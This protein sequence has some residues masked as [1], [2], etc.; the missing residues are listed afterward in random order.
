MA[1]EMVSGL[2]FLFLF[3]PNLIYQRITK[4]LMFTAMEWSC[5]KWL[6]VKFLF[7]VCTHL[8]QVFCTS[9]CLIA[10]VTM[11]VAGGERPP[12]PQG[13]TVEIFLF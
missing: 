5:M 8:R 1:P 6:A 11:K 10:Q 13:V 2:G 4:K 7:T 3:S 12:L 9:F